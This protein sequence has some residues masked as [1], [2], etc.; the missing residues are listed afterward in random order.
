MCFPECTNGGC[1][2]VQGA[3]GPVWECTTDTSCMPCAGPLDDGSTDCGSDASPE[4]S[5]DASD[6][7]DD[8]ADASADAALE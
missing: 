8:A 6:A 2:C 5:D 1:K 7:G 4:A 3:S